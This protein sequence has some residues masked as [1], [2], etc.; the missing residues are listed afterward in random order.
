MSTDNTPAMT[1]ASRL[2]VEYVREGFS[3]G[4]AVQFAAAMED[5]DPFELVERLA[6]WV[7]ADKA[8]KALA[9]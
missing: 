4:R 1:R 7:A 6:E 5:V 9:I 3:V 2:A 8:L